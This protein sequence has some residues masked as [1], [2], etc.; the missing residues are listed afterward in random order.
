M[1]NN[2]IQNITYDLII[3]QE[4]VSYIIKTAPYRYKEFRI[5]KKNKN[6]FR[7]I[8]HPSRELKRLQYWVIDNILK[9]FDIH[10]KATAYLKGKNI[11]NN[12]E[13]HK[14]N[15]YMLKL[16]FKN[17]F[18]SIKSQHF[19]YFLKN[20]NTFTFNEDDIEKL[21][22]IL[23]WSPNHDKE[24]LEL[25]IGAPSSPILSNILMYDFDKKVSSFCQKYNFAY[26]RYADDLTFSMKEKTHRE[27][28]EK[29]IEEI[30]QNLNN[31]DLTINKKKT[32][33]GSMANR[34]VV[35]GLIL[36]NEGK[37]S[38]GRDKKRLISSKIHK[39]LNNNLSKK[40]IKKL[41]GTLA[42]AYSVEPEFIKRMK[43][44]YG[45]DIPF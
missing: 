6:Q 20:N 5:K 32:V 33:Y 1:Q 4:T 13:P 38:L 7:L 12:A 19:E 11:L 26:T 24:N 43:K 30:I 36:S 40:E 41:K 8:A 3:P 42:Y 44:K 27:M 2:I 9:D 37:A 15:P 21:I 45:N 28:I 23:F 16:D 17:F 18:P 34:R 10:D 14:N 31:L 29:K 22:K 25:S 39:F 35:T